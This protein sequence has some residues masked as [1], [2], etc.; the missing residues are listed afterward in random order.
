[1]L[2]PNTITFIG[3]FGGLA[4]AA[5]L[6]IFACF[7]CKRFIAPSGTT[8]HV[9]ALVGNTMSICTI[10]CFLYNLGYFVYT[11]MKYPN[12]HD[13]LQKNALDV[14]GN[15]SLVFFALLY[16]MLTFLVHTTRAVI[17]LGK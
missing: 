12:S 10:G 13:F 9:A 7:V 15:E 2:P 6:W 5:L 4:L 16:A 8:N 14:S 1:M 3:I 11:Q 17:A